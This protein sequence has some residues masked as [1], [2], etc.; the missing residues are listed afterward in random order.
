MKLSMIQ[1]EA[2]HLWQF[3][4]A[5]DMDDDEAKGT[6]TND[7]KV[8]GNRTLAFRIRRHSRKHLMIVT[9]AGLTGRRF[10]NCARQGHVAVEI[11]EVAARWKVSG[12]KVA[13]MQ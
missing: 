13:M 3:L 8:G 12:P 10:T 9:T 1:S 6:L 11:A 2:G 7:I 5:G 4:A